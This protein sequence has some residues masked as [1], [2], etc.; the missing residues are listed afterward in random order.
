T[1]WLRW[2]N[3]DEGVEPRKRKGCIKNQGMQEEEV[4]EILETTGTKRALAS[5]FA[6]K[7]EARKRL[8]KEI[9]STLDILLTS[10]SFEAAASADAGMGNANMHH[11]HHA[12][13]D[14]QKTRVPAE[15]RAAKGGNVDAQEKTEPVTRLEEVRGACA[16]AAKAVVAGGAAAPPSP[17]VL[18][19]IRRKEGIKIPREALAFFEDMEGNILRRQHSADAARPR[20]HYHPCGP[21]SISSASADGVSVPPKP[22]LARRWSAPAAATTSAAAAAAAAAAGGDTAMTTAEMARAAEGQSAGAVTGGP[23]EPQR[24]TAGGVESGGRSSGTGGGGGGESGEEEDE[25]ENGGEEPRQWNTF[26]G[27]W[28]NTVSREHKPWAAFTPTPALGMDVLRAHLSSIGREPAKPPLQRRNSTAAAQ[29]CLTIDD[30]DVEGVIAAACVALHHHIAVGAAA[31][32]APGGHAGVTDTRRY[33]IFDD[34]SLACTNQATAARLAAATPS[35]ET[36]REFFSYV[37]R[38]AQLER[39]CVVMALVYIE[40]LLTETAGGMRICGRNWR[41]ILLCGMIL[42]SKVWDD[43]SMWN[44]DFS[45]VGRLTLECVNELEVAVLQV[46]QYNVG[47]EASNFARHY[48]HLRHWYMILGE[49]RG[50][51][52]EMASPALMQRRARRR[53]AVAAAERTALAR[54]GGAGKTSSRFAAGIGRGGGC[55]GGAIGSAGSLGSLSSDDGMCGYPLS[56]GSGSSGGPGYSQ[57]GSCGRGGIGL[58]V[59]TGAHAE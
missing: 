17:P 40:R 2:T 56:G 44:L 36:V 43:L 35:Y 28:F 9:P 59:P 39:D 58:G 1:R 47:V 18:P 42:A 4:S 7:K 21:R 51:A 37:Y 54:I 34:D 31:A 10:P 8:K 38:T 41:S 55:G 32:A 33:A 15:E 24:I 25:D 49:H 57:G 50:M 20:S 26:I 5:Q 48:F 30:M 12:S 53:R 29:L 27:G 19:P 16:T 45:K 14:M 13:S 6:P 23:A 22:K 3:F 46:L 52:A 11:C